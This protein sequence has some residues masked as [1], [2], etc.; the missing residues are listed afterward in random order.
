M[1]KVLLNTLRHMI[2]V[3]NFSIIIIISVLKELCIQEVRM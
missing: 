3:L 2:S 1:L